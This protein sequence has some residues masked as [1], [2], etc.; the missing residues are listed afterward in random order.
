MKR[1]HSVSILV[2]G[3]AAGACSGADQNDP[4]FE[5]LGEVGQELVDAAAVFGFESTAYWNVSAGTKS[6]TADHSQGAAA[7]AVRNFTYTDI[8]SVPL[9]SLSGVTSTLRL[10]VKPPAVLPWGQVQVFVT[11]PSA[12]V[13]NAPSNTV[14]LAGLTASTFSTLSFTL[15]ASAVTALQSN[16][17]DKTIKIG[18]NAPQSNADFKLDNLGFAGAGTNSLVEMRVSDVDDLLV[19]T[20]DGVRRKTIYLGDPSEGAKLDV[21]SWFGAGT[22]TIRLQNVNTGGPTN[23]RFELWVDGQQVVN[24]TPPAGVTTQGIADDRTLSVYTP[25]RP[26]LQTVTVTSSTSGRLYLDDTYTGLSTPATLSLPQGNYK[27]GLGVSTDTPPTYTG[28]FY[29]RAVTVASAS[30]SVNLTS[31]APLGLQKTNTMVIVPVKHTYNYTAAAGHDDPANDGVLADSDIPLLQGQVAVTGSQWFTPFSYGLANWQVTT[32]PA[33]TTTPLREKAPDGFAMDDFIDEAGLGS[34]RG[35]YDRIVVYFSQY[36][37]DGSYVSDHYGSVFALGRQL[38][39]YL[40]EYA[41]FRTASQPSPW[42][43]HECLHNH[44]AYNDWVLHEWNGVGGLHGAEQH[45]Y[46]SENNSGETDYVKFYRLWM[47]GQVAELDGMRPD[48]KWPSVPV[49]SDL[50]VGVFKTLRVYTG[51]P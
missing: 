12:N 50:N 4:S 10:D 17:T 5:T 18:V 20:V 21:S 46:Y 37:A 13:Y 9:G 25:N 8:T 51:K 38:V 36:K 15:P 30:Q 28:S 1:A 31:T 19:V 33:V 26:P 27:L 40:S 29:E 48:V 39:G 32:L 6:S 23:Y 43:L 44:E 14:P 11:V 24:Q 49:S 41:R 42:F 22:N 47:R 3:L 16:A 35:Q 7:L 34:L 2:L 45:G